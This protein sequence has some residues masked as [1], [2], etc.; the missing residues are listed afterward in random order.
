MI[1]Q[2]LKRQEVLKQEQNTSFKQQNVRAKVLWQEYA[3]YD[4]GSAR[5]RDA[6]GQ[7]QVK[8][9]RGRAG[10]AALS[11]FMLVLA[12]ASSAENSWLFLLLPYE[13]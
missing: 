2:E 9:S 4:Q 1:R 8:N 13:I 6:K 11:S 7:E 10:K 3:L 5:R 12:R